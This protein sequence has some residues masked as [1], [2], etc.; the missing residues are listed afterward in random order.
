VNLHPGPPCLGV[1]T[2][3]VLEDPDGLSGVHNVCGRV[4]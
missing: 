3:S 4:N 2:T 1:R